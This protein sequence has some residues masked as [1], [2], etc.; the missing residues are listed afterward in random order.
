[1]KKITII[2]VAASL[3]MTS[4]AFAQS[5]KKITA[6]QLPDASCVKTAVQKRS[7]AVTVAVDAFAAAFKNALADR[8]NAVSAALDIT[9]KKSRK[10]AM[11]NAAQTF[12]KTKK[13][14]RKT[15][16]ATRKSA[17]DGFRADMKNCGGNSDEH[18]N[19]GEDNL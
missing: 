3:I 11:K 2:A 1:M 5:E 14:A 10:N 18:G 19:A 9:N 6:E 13:A 8:T 4:A 7:T 12:R 15:F 17:W 16:D